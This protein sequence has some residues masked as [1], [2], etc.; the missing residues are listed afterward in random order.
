MT[1]VDACVHGAN[2]RQRDYAN[3]SVRHGPRQYRVA[4][5]SL[6]KR[7]GIRFRSCGSRDSAPKRVIDNIAVGGCRLTWAWRHAAA[8]AATV[9][10]VFILIHLNHLMGTLKRQSN[11][12]LYNIQQ[13][14]EGIVAADGW[15]GLLYIHLYSPYNCSTAEKNIQ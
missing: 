14:G 10:F 13:Y 3:C 11:G 15:G 2:C 1:D 7:V 8:A 12:P 6:A 9:F 5:P 4:P